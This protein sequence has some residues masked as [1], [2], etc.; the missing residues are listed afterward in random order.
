MKLFLN[1]VASYVFID[2]RF[3][4]NIPYKNLQTILLSDGTSTYNN[5][6]KHFDNSSTYIEEYNFM[7]KKINKI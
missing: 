7:K 6:N 4:N 1:D 3:V 2:S 5:F